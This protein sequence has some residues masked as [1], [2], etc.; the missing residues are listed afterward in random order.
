MQEL[1]NNKKEL[2]KFSHEFSVMA[3]IYKNI[4]RKVK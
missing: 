2:D 1:E 3:Q 4:S